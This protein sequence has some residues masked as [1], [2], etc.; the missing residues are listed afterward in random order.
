MMFITTN[1]WLC[2]WTAKPR[3]QVAQKLNLVVIH[4]QTTVIWNT[5]SGVLIV[6]AVNRTE[7]TFITDISNL[8][9]SVLSV[10]SVFVR[11]R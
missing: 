11:Q 7:R 10:S 3:I 4:D 8:Q 2:I 5:G 1:L 6:S 9:L